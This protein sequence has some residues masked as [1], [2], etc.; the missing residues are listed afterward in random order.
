MPKV[1]S[2]SKIDIS[3]SEAL[4]EFLLLKKAQ[5]NSDTTLNDYKYHV[6]TFFKRCQG[7]EK[8]ATEINHYLAEKVMPATYNIRLKYLRIFLEW[9]TTE[10]YIIKNPIKNWKYKKAEDRIVDIPEDVL[11][12]L[13]NAPNKKSFV[14]LRDY[15]LIVLTLDTG[16]RP[17]EAMSLT[18]EDVCFKQMLVSVR[19]TIAKTRVPR[20]LPI[21]S[22]AGQSIRKLISVHHEAWKT[23]LIFCTFEGNKMDR[24]R[25]ARRMNIYSNKIGY[26]I[27][28]YDL[29][30]VFALYYLRAGGDVFSLQKMMG[31]TNLNMTQKYLA[32]TGEDIKEQHAKNSPLNI[33]TT[34][35][36]VKKV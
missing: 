34:R 15:T 17:K 22:L 33:L 24:N 13:L 30:H 31:H 11:K 4:E 23:K 2:I 6:T 20:S 36:R 16:I 26:K 7:W 14:G 3:P 1:F 28:P 12:Q 25:W 18:K 21:S 5:G 9:C 19:S 10:G 35:S 32:L 27:R 29:R 8:V